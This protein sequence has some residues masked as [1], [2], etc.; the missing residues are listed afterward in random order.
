MRASEGKSEN[1][2][3]IEKR[4]DVPSMNHTKLWTFVCIT[5]SNQIKSNNVVYPRLSHQKKMLFTNTICPLKVAKYQLKVACKQAL[6]SGV[7]LSWP[8]ASVPGAPLPQSSRHSL[9]SPLAPNICRTETLACTLVKRSSVL[10]IS[11]H[12]SAHTSIRHVE[13]NEQ[14]PKKTLLISSHLCEG[15]ILVVT[16]PGRPP[17]QNTFK[18]AY[19]RDRSRIKLK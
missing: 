15:S 17:E 8:R 12:F 9:R 14:Y 5:L 1:R 7:Y 3:W 16:T 13:H 4:E 2:H 6:R 11:F 18:Q 10:I 19:P